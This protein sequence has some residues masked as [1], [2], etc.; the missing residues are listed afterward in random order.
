VVP[1]LTEAD[2]NYD[3][4]V[5]RHA[6]DARSVIRNQQNMW[7]YMGGIV[8]VGG[9]GILF[10]VINGLMER[11][12][13]EVLFNEL[14]LGIIPCGSGNG[15]AKSISYAFN[16]PHDH[17]PVLVSA[18]NV[19]RGV[20]TPLDL[21]RIETTNGV[22]YSFLSIG[23]GLLSDIDIESERL[24]SMGSQRFVVWSLARLIG[25]R[26]YRGTVSYLPISSERVL[27][28][29]HI[30]SVSEGDCES[31]VLSEEGRRDSFYSV[32]SKKSTYQS[33]AGSSYE[34]LVEDPVRTFGPPSHFPPLSQPVPSNWEV[35]KGNFVMVHASFPS[36]LATDC[37]FA[38]SARLDDGCIWL[39]II[40][41]GISRHHL[42]QFLLGLSTGTQMEVPGTEMVAV[43]G[44]RIEPES[45]G[46]HM[47][48]DGEQIEVGP[49]Q[50]QILPSAVS[51]FA[52]AH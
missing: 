36:H 35:V 38:P 2:V 30:R 11:S 31:D 7:Q 43:S 42:A 6:Q 17:N 12:D 22:I 50:A 27:F 5:T 8:V 14:K 51:V 13:W 19:V 28:R 49:I 10:E 44:F 29:K 15:L 48:V 39:C 23:W 1:L 46:S 3:L 45:G 52:R 26:T 32:G 4:H 37:F 18:L 20:S 34:S 40:R 24:R 33:I 16:E 41:S 47:A 9:D 21:V 25:L